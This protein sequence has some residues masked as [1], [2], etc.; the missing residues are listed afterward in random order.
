MSK[1]NCNFARQE[2]SSALR[3]M[4]FLSVME[5]EKLIS[6]KYPGREVLYL[7]DKA[8]GIQLPDMLALTVSESIKT[9][10]TVQ[11]IWDW[12]L[13][14]HATRR[15]LLVCVG[16]GVITD[17]GGFAAA[18][19]RR[20]IDYIN[21][22]TTLLAMVD[23]AVGGKTGFD[24]RGLKNS[25][26]VIREP[27]ET[28]ILP[29]WLQTLPDK[30]VLS[31]YAELIKTA[32]LDNNVMDL[33]ALLK[34]DLRNWEPYITQAVEVKKRIVAADPTEQGLRKVLN[35]GHTIG[36]ALEELTIHQFTDSS[37]HPIN[38]GFAV[39][40]GLVAELYLS[41]VLLGLDKQVLQQITH[42][43]MENYGRPVCSCKDY[44]RLIELMRDDKKNEQEGQIN[45]T[46]L[47]AV[48]QP[49]INQVVEEKMIREAL[50]YLFTL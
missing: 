39:M 46:L 12:L 18:T 43:M 48:G 10:A 22:P 24:Y 13:D 35:L 38:H 26:G 6:H 11:T 37:I 17:L 3:C 5:I 4:S 44:D 45:F 33:T 21:V 25:I 8:L 28:I 30:D 36:H 42:V 40:Y 50:E 2:G 23:A 1:K 14:H 9:L 27:L 32:L 49:V 34:D 20:G 19:Y 7:V 47:R 41:V 15:T 29:E 31:G 16:G